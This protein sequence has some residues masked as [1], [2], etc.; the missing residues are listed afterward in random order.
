MLAADAKSVEGKTLRERMIAHRANPACATCHA[1][2]D[3][4]GFGLENFDPIG[5]W[6]TKEGD[7]GIDASGELPN[8]EKFSGASELKAILLKQKNQ[9]AHAFSEK[10]LTYALGRGIE[11]SDKCHVDT[12]AKQV[13][14][15]DYKFSSV[16]LSI[17]KSDPFLKRRTG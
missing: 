5:A 2:M 4:L 8:G 10:L 1:K 13:A 14:K 12:I 9:F 3:P 7:L 15:G 11:L 6:R 17:V 16:V